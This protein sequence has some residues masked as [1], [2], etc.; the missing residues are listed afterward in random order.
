MIEGSQIDWGGHDMDSDYIISETLDFDK[1]IKEVLEFAK[2]DKNTLVLITA[3]H[4]TGGYGIIGGDME[5]NTIKTSFLNDDH[6]ATM[7]PLFAF[8][9][10]SNNFIGT[11]D[12]TEV[13]QK[14]LTL[15]KLSHK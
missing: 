7:V 4:E 2:N 15:F 10:M 6:T 8:G 5:K 12:N 13:Y 1:A 3:D 14:I 11:Y 9:P